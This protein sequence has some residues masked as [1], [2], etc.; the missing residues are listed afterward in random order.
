MK[1]K[2]LTIQKNVFYL[3]ETNSDKKILKNTYGYSEI[4][5]I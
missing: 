1:Q 2:F 5:Y 4:N 3:S